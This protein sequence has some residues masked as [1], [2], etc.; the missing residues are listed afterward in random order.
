MI[1]LGVTGQT[2]KLDALSTESYDAHGRQPLLE[3]LRLERDACTRT[4]CRAHT[5]L[6]QAVSCAS[7]IL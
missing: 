3:I 5:Y 4:E 6:V 1:I 7:I 2:C